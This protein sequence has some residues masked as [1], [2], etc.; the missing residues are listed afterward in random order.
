MSES[1]KI[2]RRVRFFVACE[3]K[4]ELVYARFIEEV[5]KD[6]GLHITFEVCQYYGGDPSVIA[7]GAITDAADVDSSA[8]PIRAKFLFLDS[9][10]LDE[11]S[12]KDRDEIVKMLQ[13]EGFI[14]IWQ[15]P[16]HEGFLLRHF[17]GHEND[18]PQRGKSLRALKAVWPK[19]DKG[20]MNRR[21]YIKD[22]T[23]NHVKRAAD[24]HPDLKSFLQAIGL[25][26]RDRGR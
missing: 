11:K 20:K 3:G 23:L 16:D 25:V 19:Y 5:A 22:I 9:D 12:K 1:T 7:S 10:R 24:R 13:D 2:K 17:E 14:V 6:A 18:R 21:D 4:S 26:K 15:N 8:D